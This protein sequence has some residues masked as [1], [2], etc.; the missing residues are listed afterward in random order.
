MV[1]ASAFGFAISPASVLGATYLQ[2]VYR[3]E[4]WQTTVLM[5]SCGL[6]SLGLAIGAGRLS[7]RLGRRP[8]AF[9]IV[10]LAGISFYFFYS[11]AP[12]WAMPLLWLLAFFGFFSG[13]AL[14]AGFA[15]EIVPTE[16]RATVSGL[17][18]VFEISCGAVALWLEGTLYHVYQAHAPAIQL[19]LLSLP[20]TL[21][22]LLLLPEPAGKSLE[23]MTGT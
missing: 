17:R 11:G 22:V 4:P 15:L 20:I 13:D 1:A 23:E 7:D 9:A 2:T 10:L 3:Y 19:C 16:Y 12:G 14:I 21:I 8:L 6:V 5:V 18:Y